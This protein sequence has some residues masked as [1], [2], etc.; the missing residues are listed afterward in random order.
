MLGQNPRKAP[1]LVE[2]VIERCGRGADYV[3]FAEIAL[4]SGRFEF[5]EEFPRMLVDLDR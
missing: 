5:A 4:Y 2:G 3:R 1:D